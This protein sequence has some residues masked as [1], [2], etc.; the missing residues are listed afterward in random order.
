LNNAIRFFTTGV[1]QGAEGAYHSQASEYG[2]LVFVRSTVH[3]LSE[4]GDRKLLEAMTLAK[5]DDPDADVSGLA[6]KLGPEG[7]AVVQLLENQDPGRTEALIAELPGPVRA[8]LDRLTLANKPLKRL[9]AQLILV[10]GRD[11]RL[12][13]YTE[14]LA[15]AKAVKEE[16]AHVYLIDRILGHVDLSFSD[17]FSRGFWS[18]ELPDAWRLWRAQTRLLKERDREPQR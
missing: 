10:H 7:R 14:S 12:I 11:D 15:L 8:T 5:L 3:L 13:P 17:V 1:A 16:Q 4:P 9:E 6:R 2:K 18:D